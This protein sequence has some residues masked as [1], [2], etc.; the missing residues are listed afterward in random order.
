[1]KTCGL[2][3]QLGISTEETIVVPEDVV[4]NDSKFVII[5][6]DYSGATWTVLIVNE[7]QGTRA[8]VTVAPIELY[9]DYYDIEPYGNKVR[10]LVAAADVYSE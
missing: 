4:K 2:D 6:G 7:S 10:N 1:M 5:S 3:N 8:V 9:E